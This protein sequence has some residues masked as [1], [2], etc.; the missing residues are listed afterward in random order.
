MNTENKKT[1]KDIAIDE[2]KEVE[3]IE[4]LIALP[5]LIEN[6]KNELHL[7]EEIL[8]SLNNE[9]SI[10]IIENDEI[11]KVVE[12]I[13]DLFIGNTEE[14]IIDTIIEKIVTFFDNKDSILSSDDDVVLPTKDE[15]GIVTTSNNPETQ[16]DILLKKMQES[17]VKPTSL[18]PT[19]RDHSAL[20]ASAPAPSTPRAIDPYRELP[21]E[22]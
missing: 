6:I 7:S 21:D 12:K 16:K 18:A 1:I 17:F 14:P 2:T 9:L 4:L 10:S 22:K 8:F 3:K 11:K 19:T 5:A 13:E 15:S 20:P